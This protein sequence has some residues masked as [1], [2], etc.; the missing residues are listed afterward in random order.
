LVRLK[1]RRERP[2]VFTGA[3]NLCCSTQRWCLKRGDLRRVQT[4]RTIRANLS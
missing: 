4:T 2:L 3:A 1:P